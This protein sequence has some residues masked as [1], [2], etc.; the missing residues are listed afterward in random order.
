MI[1][2]NFIQ[3]HYSHSRY[4]AIFRY[5]Y[6]LIVD[7]IFSLSACISKFVFKSFK[8]SLVIERYA[9]LDESKFLRHILLRGFNGVTYIGKKNYLTKKMR[10]RNF[11]DDKKVLSYLSSIRNYVGDPV[12]PSAVLESALLT[13]G[14]YEKSKHKIHLNDLVTH[15]INPKL[16]NFSEKIFVPNEESFFHFYIQTI[17]FI[18]KH[19]SENCLYLNLNPESF[20]LEVL[21]TLGLNVTPAINKQ[22]SDNV[23]IPIQV[24]HYPSR[25][26]VLYLRNYLEN[27]GYIRR[28]TQN[29]Y[30][31]R[32]GNLNG[33]HVQNE[34]ELLRILNRYNF[35]S[36]NP[37][38]LSFENQ[39]EL[40]S[41]ANIVI[42]PHGAALSHVVNFPNDSHVLEL[43][44]NRD[45]RWHIRTMCTDLKIKHSILLG[46]SSHNGN[47][48]V[49]L[50][51]VRDF[52]NKA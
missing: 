46:K 5:F 40:F 30:I 45:V 49:N 14:T 28:P 37:D 20:H 19:Q 18:L 12:V 33:R 52:L 8:I 39:L 3:R 27:L 41:K 32:K 31:S 13:Y 25:V 24:G 6:H 2:R 36:V 16:E 7:P 22:I 38:E 43:N 1:G 44:G 21:K 17:P 34:T 50:E 51:L 29:I 42:G 9:V 11:R 47:F 26:D 15:L 10:L 48:E 4:Y 23:S 35:L